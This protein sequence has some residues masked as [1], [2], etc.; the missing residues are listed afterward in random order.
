MANEKMTLETT[1][2]RAYNPA[3]V[4]GQGYKLHTRYSFIVKRHNNK[5][6]AEMLISIWNDPIAKT[7]KVGDVISADV[8]IKGKMAKDKYRNYITFYNT[9]KINQPTKEGAELVG[10]DDNDAPF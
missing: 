8:D 4:K 7:L 6:Q 1:I 2:V 3:Q 10:V 9:T 5:Y